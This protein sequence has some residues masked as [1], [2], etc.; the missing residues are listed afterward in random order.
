MNYLFQVWDYK[1]EQ[2]IEPCDIHELVFEKKWRW[3]LTNCKELG[4]Y[5]YDHEINNETSKIELLID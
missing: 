5:E 2:R 1:H 4:L 3:Y